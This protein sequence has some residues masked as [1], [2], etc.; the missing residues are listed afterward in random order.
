[1]KKKNRNSQDVLL[2]ITKELKEDPLRKFKTSFAVMGIIS[3]LVFLCLFAA[4]AA[5]ATRVLI[6]LSITYLLGFIFGYHAISQILQKLMFYTTQLKKSEQLKS[7]LVANVSH[8]VRNPLTTVKLTI[9]NLLDGLAGSINDAQKI[10]IQR[11]Q[12]TIDRLIRL[13]SQLLD[14][15]KIEAGKFT[16][17]RSLIDVTHLINSEIENF[18][19]ALKNKKLFLVKESPTAPLKIWGDGD[20]ITQVFFNLFDNAIKYTLENGRISVKW[21]DVRGYAWIEIE[22]TGIGIPEDKREKIFDKFE[23]IMEGK[24]L[25][26]GLG[27]PIAKDIVEMHGGQLLVDSIQGKGSKFT[28]VLPVDLRGGGRN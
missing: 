28:V 4:G 13:V 14:L 17:Q 2:E 10:L 15:S 7:T 6:L 20:K 3:F 12:H 18:D 21:S 11:C 16:L 27:L 9:S 22:D 8:E 19:P 25:G 23:R 26:A 1:M 24:E 5:N